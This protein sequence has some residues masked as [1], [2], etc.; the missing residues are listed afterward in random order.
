[1]KDFN[2]Y[3]SIYDYYDGPLNFT[4][5]K[6]GSNQ[7]YYAHLIDVTNDS[8]IFLIVAVSEKRMKEAEKCTI[9]LR[10]LMLQPERDAYDIMD[11]RGEVL[12]TAIDKNS[13]LTLFPEDAFPQSDTTLIS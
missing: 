4:F 10:T 5:T 7:L 8:D 1:M 6:K 3:V 13:L 11:S 12:H 9:D 2:E